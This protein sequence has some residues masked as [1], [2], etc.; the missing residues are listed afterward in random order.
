[1]PFADTRRPT[2][3]LQVPSD[4]P[5]YFPSQG[6]QQDQEFFFARRRHDVRIESLIRSLVLPD[7]PDHDA[8]ITCLKRDERD[9]FNA[10]DA[11]SRAGNALP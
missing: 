5:R 2:L 10:L 4:A 7:S 8:V 1:V 11:D 9:R 6:E 3:A